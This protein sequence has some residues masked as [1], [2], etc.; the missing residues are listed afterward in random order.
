MVLETSALSSSLNAQS[1]ND[2]ETGIVARPRPTES[3]SSDVRRSS[4]FLLKKTFASDL[5]RKVGVSRTSVSR[6]NVP[7]GAP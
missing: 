2:S 6:A 4:S 7:G 5:S 1:L 3:Q